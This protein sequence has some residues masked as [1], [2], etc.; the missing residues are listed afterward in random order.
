[1]KTKAAGA[2]VR[3]RFAQSVLRAR[4]A[5]ETLIASRFAKVIKEQLRAVAEVVAAYEGE[6][7]IELELL[8]EESVLP[9]TE[10]LANAL[11]FTYVTRGVPYAMKYNRFVSD[12]GKKGVISEDLDFLEYSFTEEMRT[13]AAKVSGSKIAAINETTLSQVKGVLR[14][15]WDGGLGIP[16]MS[17]KIRTSATQISKTRSRVIARTESVQAANIAGRSGAEATGLELR[18]FWDTSGL[19]NIRRS[20]LSAEGEG[21]LKMEERF[22]ST[23]M[24]M[25]GDPGGAVSEIVNCRCAT[26]Y[27]PVL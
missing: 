23:K 4:Q 19:P 9:Y 3:R 7:P 18:K 6:S 25:V 5:D 24:M 12:R 14:K 8:V 16:D 1:V 13:Y 20:H 11:T 10:G 26:V 21:G 27:L 22:A 2:R 15:S 17:E